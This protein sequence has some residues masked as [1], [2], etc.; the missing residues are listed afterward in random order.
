M[1]QSRDHSKEPLI[2]QQSTDKISLKN[3]MSKTDSIP[4][5]EP[6]Q[7][8][9]QQQQN[10]ECYELNVKLK[11]GKNLAVRDLC[12]SSDP[13]VKFIL[14]GSTVYKSKIIFKNLNPQWNEEFNIK[15]SP[16]LIK[17]ITFSDQI[18]PKMADSA[19]LIS[20]NRTKSFS[21]ANLSS[22]QLEYF[23]S[24]FKLKIFV[25]DYDRGFLNDDLIGYASIDLAT[26]KENM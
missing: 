22:A 7:Q 14:N 24:K 13:Y 16:S 3:Q 26:L 21:E 4:T 8:Q 1:D 19:S 23:L 5:V 2:K 9:Q 25:Y 10:L 18:G 11:E 17:E 6:K 15:L 20:W 12:G